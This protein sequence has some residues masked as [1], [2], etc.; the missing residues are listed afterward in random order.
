MVHYSPG[1][2][3]D[4]GDAGSVVPLIRLGDEGGGYWGNYKVRG[5]WR[6]LVNEMNK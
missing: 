5:L 3:G 4:V 1:C 2:Y 6:N